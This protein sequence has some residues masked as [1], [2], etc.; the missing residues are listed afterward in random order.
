MLDHAAWQ[1]V[2]SAEA[3]TLDFLMRDYV[4]HLDHH[5]RQIDALVGRRVS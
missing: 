5:L 1:T 2:P 3:T 4:A